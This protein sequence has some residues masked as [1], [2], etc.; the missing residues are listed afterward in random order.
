MRKLRI[1][2]ENK[3]YE[4]TVE[5][6]TD[7]DDYRAPLMPAPAPVSA[8]SGV[9]PPQ[10][11]ESTKPTQP[12]AAGAVTSPMA[13]VIQSVSVKPGDSVQV[14]QTL[15]VLEAMKMENQITAPAA[16]TVREVN[17]KAGDS[18]GEGQVLVV[19]E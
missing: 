4:V 13:G 6:L 19:V 11:V 14:G 7:P 17:V 8:P 1:T 18:V 3:S 5:D 16:G 15:V 12:A 9:T 2:I 10:R